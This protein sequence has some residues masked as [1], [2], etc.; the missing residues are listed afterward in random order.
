ILS[1]LKNTPCLWRDA[2]HVEEVGGCGYAEN[3][4]RIIAPW[5]AEIAEL[6][7]GD[8]GENI[9]LLAPVFEVG[10]GG[11]ALNHVW[12]VFPDFDEPLR[13]PE[14]QWSKQHG[15]YNAEDRAVGPD[16]QS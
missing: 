1:F 2:Y 10:D 11:R 16:P 5:Q 4:L 8:P 7:R 12:F 9:I 6:I 13:L 14:R 3:A 15:I